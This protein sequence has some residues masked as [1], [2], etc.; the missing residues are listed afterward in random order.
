MKMRKNYHFAFTKRFNGLGLIL[1][2]DPPYTTVRKSWSFEIRGG[3]FLFWYI[4]EK[5]L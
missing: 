4:K 3:W 1:V 5:K 2:T